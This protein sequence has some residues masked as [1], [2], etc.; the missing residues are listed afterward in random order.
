MKTTKLLVLPILLSAL[1]TVANTIP[2]NYNS[3]STTI[4]ATPFT[5][6]RYDIFQWST[7]MGSCSTDPKLSELTWK[8]HIFETGVKVETK[9]EDKNFNFLG[10]LKYGI[11]LNQSN[12]QDSDWDNLGEFS[13]V[14]SSVKGNVF[15]LSGAIGV[16]RQVS[17]V[18]AT[19]Y[20]G[21]DYTN[22]QIKDYGLNY[23]VNR[24]RYGHTIEELGQVI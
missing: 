5:G 12:R 20:F 22:Y 8:N 6:Y 21:M 9:P 10:Q 7:P 1:T 14:M 24:S 18:L 2:L 13:K 11:I 19:Y 16:S 4:S 23:K 15:D 3:G 17:S